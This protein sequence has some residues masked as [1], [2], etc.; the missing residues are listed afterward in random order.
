[1]LLPTLYAIQADFFCDPVAL[2]LSEHP[3]T[4]YHWEAYR[5]FPYTLPVEFVND[6]LPEEIKTFYE[7]RSH[8]L[9]CLVVIGSI[10]YLVL[11]AVLF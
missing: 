10:P 4:M 9:T 1:M 8:Y 5:D 3:A 7:K 11:F 6:F 2:M